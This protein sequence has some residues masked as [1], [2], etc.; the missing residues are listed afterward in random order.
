MPIKRKLQIVNTQI[1]QVYMEN[2]K[3]NQITL[4]IRKIRNISVNNNK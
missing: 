2:K 1:A 3:Q 4:K